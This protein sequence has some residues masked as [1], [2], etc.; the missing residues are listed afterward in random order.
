MFIAFKEQPEM[1]NLKD[2]VAEIQKYANFYEYRPNASEP[3][4]KIEILWIYLHLRETTWGVSEFQNERN[5]IVYHYN[6]DNPVVYE[7][8]FNFVKAVYNRRN[9]QKGQ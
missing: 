4:V 5:N 1:Q 2:L 7:K 6:D 9:P 3:L 8:L